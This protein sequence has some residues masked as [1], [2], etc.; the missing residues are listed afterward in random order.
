LTARSEHKPIW[1]AEYTLPP[2]RAELAPRERLRAFEQAAAAMP[3][4]GRPW[5]EA[6]DLLLQGR[7]TDDD[8]GAGASPDDAQPLRVAVVTPYCREELAV[9]RRCHESVLA[10]TYPCRHVVVADGLPRDEIDAWS[11]EHV[12]LDTSHADYGDT[13]R[14]AGGARALAVGCDAI[15]YLDADKTLR[16]RHVESLVRRQR[17]TGAPVVFSG[18]TINFPDGATL[19]IVDPEDGS[20]HID[21]NCLLLAADSL[22]MASA[23]LAYPRPLS[24]IDDRMVVQMLKARGFAFAC[25]GALTARYTVN[26]AHLYREMGRA[27]PPGARARFDPTPVV[28]YYRGLT[29]EE[30]NELDATLGFAV[31]AFL[32]VLCRRWGVELD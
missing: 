9:L 31:G 15:A 6:L 24:M 19:P 7:V 8:V 11:V 13:P 12:R 27:V 26:F 5:G 4:D 25:T 30:R 29:R 18:R 32:R 2:P 3:A 14:A 22:S 10:Q 16:P 23:W 20:T 1:S 17:A 21:T 28:A